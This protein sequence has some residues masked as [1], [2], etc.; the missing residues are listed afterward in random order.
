MHNVRKTLNSLVIAHLNAAKVADTAHIVTPQIHQHIMLRDFLGICQK[1]LL[2]RLVLLTRP[3]AAACAGNRH[4]DDLFA[5]HLHQ[6]FR[7]AAGDFHIV[8]M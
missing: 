6:C 3:A 1:L 8:I 7:R 4:A 5:N 2:Q